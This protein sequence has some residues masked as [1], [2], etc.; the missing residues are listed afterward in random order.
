MAF[1]LH[2]DGKAVEFPLDELKAMAR[3]GELA[4]DEYVY[5]DVKGEWLGAAM[6]PELEGAWNIEESEATVA[7]QLPP[8]FF[9][10]FDGDGGAPAADSPDGP[11]F[12]EVPAPAP[13]AAAA[14]APAPAPAP[15]PAGDTPAQEEEATRAM[16]LAEL[17]GALAPSSSQQQEATVAMETPFSEPEPRPEPRPEPAPAQPRRPQPRPRQRA[18]TPAAPRTGTRPVGKTINSAIGAVLGLFTCG[19][20]SLYWMFRVSKETNTFMGREEL[21]IWVVPA[22]VVAG[23]LFGGG[24]GVLTGGLAGPLGVVPCLA[25]IAWWGYKLGGCVAEMATQSRLS[26]GDRQVVYAVCAV[27]TP[28]LIFL[29][30]EDLNAIWNANGGKRG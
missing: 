19:I 12:K 13:A 20:Y 9:D 23:F 17:E 30:Q 18:A 7:M 2:R 3:R 22:V 5:D 25:L 15:T 14:P 28:V 1:H 21:P 11:T 16:D 27:F 8:D 4:Q 6:V 26:I 10:N 24:M 29:A